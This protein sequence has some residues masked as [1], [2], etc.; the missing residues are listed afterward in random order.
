M[1]YKPPNLHVSPSDQFNQMCPSGRGLIP[2]GDLLYGVPTAASYKGKTKLTP[3]QVQ[4]YTSYL[5]SFLTE[6]L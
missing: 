1:D 5:H 6:M 3:Q 4:T 2:N